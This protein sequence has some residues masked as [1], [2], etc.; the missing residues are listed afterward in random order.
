MNPS[1]KQTG[2][3]ILNEKL[4]FIVGC[5]RS[6]TTLL[7]LILETHSLIQCFDETR[8]YS[9]LA[10]APQQIKKQIVGFKIPRWTEQLDAPVLWDFGLLE[11]PRR[12]YSGQKIIFIVRDVRDTIASMLK[13]RVGD[14]SW[15]EAWAVPI[16]K[17][18]TDQDPSF[19]FQ[20]CRELQAIRDSESSLIAVAALYWKYKNAA[21]LHYLE[22]EIPFFPSGM[23]I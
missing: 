12:F 10:G 9:V 17:T 16:I 15:L 11:R 22:E 1:L 20:Y 23:K 2:S 7:R 13:L 4:F 14:Q 21:L 3:A 6:G 5:Q 8:A 19:T 18:K